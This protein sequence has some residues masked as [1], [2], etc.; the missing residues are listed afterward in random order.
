MIGFSYDQPAGCSGV[1]LRNVANETVFSAFD[2][3]LLLFFFFFFEAADEGGFDVGDE[4]STSTIAWN[5][6]LTACQQVDGNGSTPAHRISSRK[7]YP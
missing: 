4:L 6:K 1:P 5:G 7:A 2:S 3:E